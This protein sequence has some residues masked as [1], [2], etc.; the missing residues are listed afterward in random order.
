MRDFDAFN[1]QLEFRFAPTRVYTIDF[2]QRVEE[3]EAW[4]VRRTHTLED[5]EDHVHTHSVKR[6][7]L[8]FCLPYWQVRFC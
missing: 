4:L 3:R 6:K 7:S 1:G 8:F 5:R 2:L